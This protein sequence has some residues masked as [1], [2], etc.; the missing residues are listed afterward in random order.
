MEKR[1]L[2][3]I[4]LSF[5]VLFAYQML[6]PKPPAKPL[7]RPPVAAAGKTAGAGPAGPAA[8][9]GQSKA[10]TGTAPAPGAPAN[11]ALETAAAA[12]ASTARV[13]DTAE[14][15]VVVDTPSV[16]AVFSNRGALLKSWILKKYFDDNGKPI[17]IA[18]PVTPTAASRPFAISVAD[19][20]TSEALQTALY[21]PSADSLQ[22]DGTS[23]QS[24]TFDYEDANGLAAHKTFVF[25]PE[26]KPYV[27]S[28]NATVTQGG[29]P[30]QPVTIHGGAGLGDL[31]RAVR[32]GGFFHPSNYQQ[33]EA[34]FQIGTSVTRVPHTKLSQQPV[35]EG[36]F[37]YIGVDD[38]Y[39]I[40]V[41]FFPTDAPPPVR[42]EYAPLEIPMLSQALAP[43]GPRDLVD[44]RI[45]VKND[46]PVRF[47]YG[48]KDFD[49][50]KS[51][52]KELVRAINFGIFSFLAVP[53]LVALKWINQYIG[54]FG[55]S[56]IL[57][58]IAINL[59]LFPLRHKSVVSMRR[60]QEIQPQVKAIQDR[61]AKL[62]VTD[63]ARQK[64][65]Q[66][67]MALYKEKG[68]NPASGCVPTLLTLP[69]LFAF[70]ALLSVA[71]EL[72]GAPFAF[73][74]HDLSR[75]DP[76]FV[77]PVLMG[78][79]QFWQT[80]MTPTTGDPAQQRMMM[81]MPLMFMV[82]FVWAPSGLVIYWFVSNLW[83]IGQMYLTN[84]LIGPPPP[85]GGRTS[86]QARSN[87]GKELVLTPLR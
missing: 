40:G 72:R 31:E 51:T 87:A 38:H 50:L 49:V 36:A 13:A 35:Q 48:P 39:F 21:K 70:Y 57:L 27:V 30:Q 69:V 78:A 19:V 45:Q 44:Y 65:N 60:M 56:I 47:F 43:T 84:Q 5:V 4:S 8:T 22:I 7:P 59:V 17:D 52:D 83:S 25:Q 2:L 16:H 9:V 37:R 61:Y 29:K 82:F 3:A 32:A 53:L 75:Y 71:I 63:P 11:P 77:T 26:G 86:R 12:A 80:R 28:V 24:L 73:W 64:M 10:P 6:V 68:V 1:V 55:W 79:T 33:P 76:Y 18:P 67:L 34:I 54:N 66:D 74:I 81:F 85:P 62:K 46:G 58:T 14:R 23:S 20:G 41:A 15:D 42:V